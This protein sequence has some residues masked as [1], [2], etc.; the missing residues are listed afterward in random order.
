MYCTK[1]GLQ[2]EKK[3][4]AHHKYKQ[5][6]AMTDSEYIVSSLKAEGHRYMYILYV[7]MVSSFFPP[8]VWT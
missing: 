2:A 5:N 8:A 6:I 4:Q 7:F 1:P 3:K